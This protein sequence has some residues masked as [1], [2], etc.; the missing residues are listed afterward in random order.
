MNLACTA[1]PSVTKN[2]TRAGQWVPQVYPTVYLFS[3]LKA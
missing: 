2:P 3:S 1:R